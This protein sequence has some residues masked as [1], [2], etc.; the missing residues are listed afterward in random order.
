MPLK[1]VRLKGEKMF[2]LFKKGP[3]SE[4]DGLDC[5]SVTAHY[6]G[7]VESPEYITDTLRYPERDEQGHPYHL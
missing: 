3:E 7:E 2:G 6:E 1:S 5:D 4:D